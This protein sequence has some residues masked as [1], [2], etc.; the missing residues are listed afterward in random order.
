[1]GLASRDRPLSPERVCS[2]DSVQDGVSR[3]RA[4]VCQI[5]GFPSFHRSEGRVFPDTRSSGVE[6]AIEVPVGGGGGGGVYQFKPLCFRLST[7]PQVFTLVFAVVSAWVH[8]H[9][10][11]LLRYLDDWLVLASSETEAKKSVQD[12]LSLCHSLGIVIN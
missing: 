6:E 9:G 10:I 1:M 2:A 12:L 5:G 3:L 4:S 7:A 8:S 11:R